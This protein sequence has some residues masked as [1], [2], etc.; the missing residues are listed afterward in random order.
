LFSLE[1]WF[2]W[3]GSNFDF[4]RIFTLMVLFH[5]LIGIGEALIS[6]LALKQVL[7]LRPDLVLSSR[8]PD[9]EPKVAWGRFVTAACVTT[10]A[11]A[12]FVAP[13]ASS[14]PDGLEAVGERA[15]FSE[16]GVAPHVSLLSHYA[17]PPPVAAWTGTRW[18]KPVSVSL[19]G[20]GGVL[21]ILGISWGVSRTKKRVDPEAAS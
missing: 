1:F 8:S 11:I 17:V 13:F 4:I 19:A 20:I 10:L 14:R 7:D 16:M 12:A 5:S 9:R 21:V 18:W 6:V 3:H 2:S 15:D